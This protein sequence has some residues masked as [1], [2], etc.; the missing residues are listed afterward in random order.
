MISSSLGAVS[1]A[2]LTALLLLR[3]LTL[4]QRMGSSVLEGPAWEGPAPDSPHRALNSALLILLL[5]L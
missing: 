4:L 2:A 5:D 3:L 1:T